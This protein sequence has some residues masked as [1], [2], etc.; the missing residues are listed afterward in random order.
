MKEAHRVQ[1]DLGVAEAIRWFAFNGYTVS[2]PIGSDSQ[3]YDL[4]VDKDRTL[5]R[6]EVKT[7]NRRNTN[8]SAW[9]VGLRTIGGTLSTRRITHL[10]AEEF[11]LLFVVTPDSNY[12]IPSKMVDGMNTICV[13]GRKWNDFQL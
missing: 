8:G 1:G 13:G 3:R 5:S 9:E 2:L 10:S 7:T 4:V 11:D 6:V 12:L